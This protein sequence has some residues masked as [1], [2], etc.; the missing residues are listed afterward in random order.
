MEKTFSAFI[1]I[2][3]RPNVGKSSLL[4]RFVGE[5]V[6][7]VS[8]KPQTTRTRI[9]GVF[10]EGETQFVFIDTP[11]LHNP[12]TK[13]SEFMVKQIKDSVV[14]VDAAVLVTEPL[15]KIHPMELE[16]LQRFRDLR[17]PA[18]L[19]INKID[20]IPKKDVMME[21]ISAFSKLF[22][23]EA[24]VPVSALTGDG[25]PQLLA[26]LSHYAK[27]GPH[28]F[29]DDAM[30]DQP[31]RVIV[32]E[33]IREKLLNCLSEEIPHGTAVTVEQMVEREEK[34]LIDI[35]AVIY[36]E[37]DSHKGIIIGKQGTMLKKVASQARRDIESFLDIK[38]NLQCWVKVKE[39]W[40]NRPGVIRDLGFRES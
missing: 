6:A 4:N 17:I 26:E 12:R 18:I 1:A 21:K 38:V 8:P 27:E 13:L 22:P 19:A 2:V 15:G 31:E 29:P 35:H 30:T 37:K 7:I 39:D 16:L 10:T 34:D 24:V 25:M 9:T 32:A 14:D 20:T 5:K 40:R 28:Y 23:F 36:C 33:I 3:G 11:G